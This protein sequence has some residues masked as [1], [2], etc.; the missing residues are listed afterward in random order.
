[1]CQQ[2]DRIRDTVGAVTTGGTEPAHVGV[3]KRLNWWDRSTGI[4]SLSGAVTAVVCAPFAKDPSGA[5]D[6]WWFSGQVAGVVTAAVAPMVATWRAKKREAAAGER[7]IE[8]R[9]QT[10]LEMNEALDPIVRRLATS[11]NN[12][13][14]GVRREV[15][16][17]VTKTAAE[18]IGPDGTRSCY[19][20]LLPGPPKTLVP[21]D[22]HAGRMGSTRSRFVAG[23]VD[24]DAAIAMVESSGHRLCVDIGIDPPPGWNDKERDYKTFISVAVV[25]G[26]TAYGM[27]TVDAMNPGDLEQRDVDLLTVMAGLLA[28]AMGMEPT[29]G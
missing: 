1:M 12:N 5:I 20:D 6:V 28:T 7:E 14:V 11:A 18:I 4:I 26:D 27:L 13:V 19:F 23:T 25:G 22:Y 3:W 10:R 21:T 2:D 24:G 9:T 16:S 29:A 8:A 15:L 17:L